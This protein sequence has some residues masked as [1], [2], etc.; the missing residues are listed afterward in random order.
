MLPG[1]LRIYSTFVSINGEICEAHQGSLCTFVRFAGCNLR[2]SWCDTKYA[3]MEDSGLPCTIREVVTRVL[4]HGPRNV[5]I[6][7]GEPM[8]QKEA[9]NLL[10]IELS[11]RGFFLSVETNGSFAFD[12]LP[13]VNYVVDFKLPS[14]G[15]YDYM[16][17]ESPW[18]SLRFNDWIKFVV[19]NHTDYETACATI[20]ML[21]RKGCRANFAMSPVF[22][23]L[24]VNR[25]LQWLKFD[26][27]FDVVISAQ[28][29]KLTDLNESP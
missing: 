21:K 13:Q 24:P 5:T 15:E 29:H 10:C 22:S 23:S 28:L 12:P 8:L 9:L 26:R 14:S 20:D 7:G 11:A 17:A 3:Q 2:C 16:K 19:A 6:T 1:N 18:M 25:I 27:R 4:Q